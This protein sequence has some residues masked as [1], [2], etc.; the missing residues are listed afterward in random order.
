MLGCTFR[1]ELVL[2][3]GVLCEK[4]GVGKTTLA[5]NLAAVAHM[6]GRRTIVIDQ[7]E[8]GSAFR[9]WSRYR[10]EGSRLDGISVVKADADMSP[11][12]YRE[13]WAGCDVAIIDGPPRLAE[14]TE[15]AANVCDVVLTPLLAGAY[16]LDAVS[17]TLRALNR[18][19]S[20]RV[21]DGRAPVVRA[22]A[23]NRARST[24]MSREAERII[25][26][27]R[28]T[29]VG[30]LSDAV[31]VSETSRGGSLVT[32]H[33]TSKAALE[34]RRI[35]RELERASGHTYVQATGRTDARA[36]VCP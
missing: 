33:P 29:Y 2:V 26:S 17:H 12:R 6:S 19:D 20:R 3:I 25:Q 27:Q 13:M 14:I 10:S 5:V 8:Q 18:V 4:G 28:G 24:V 21:S 35:F 15:S 30:S 16:D 31:A 32:D 36:S 34:I 11:P 22:F 7:D 23:L 1:G 9:T